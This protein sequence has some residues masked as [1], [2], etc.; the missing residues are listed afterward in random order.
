MKSKTKAALIGL[1]GIVLGGCASTKYNTKLGYNPNGWKNNQY[2]FEFSEKE[3]PM[4][5][6]AWKETEIDLAHSIR[7]EISRDEWFK[8]E[9][10]KKNTK[11]ICFVGAATGENSLEARAK[12]IDN[13]WYNAST[14]LGFKRYDG[15]TKKFLELALK[16]HVKIAELETKPYV[17]GDEIG[18]AYIV[19]PENVVNSMREISFK[20]GTGEKLSRPTE[21]DVTEVIRFS[22]K[23]HDAT[24]LGER[25]G[26]QM[27]VIPKKKSFLFY[28][29]SKYGATKDN[30]NNAVNF[31]KSELS[32][33]D[34][35]LL[36]LLNDPEVKMYISDVG[37]EAAAF[38]IPTTKI[39][40]VARAKIRADY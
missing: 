40:E 12:A 18:T 39:D 17:L 38:K 15:D 3:N 31:V 8:T 20:Y 11:Y 30:L 1:A 16:K 21:R 37:V 34:E 23:F 27:T 32:I 29:T 26:E 24:N 14:Q 19:I 25:L 33:N 6:D 7:P 9:R 2:K 5:M 28:A 35:Q 13:A 36:T 10:S 4:F 22:K